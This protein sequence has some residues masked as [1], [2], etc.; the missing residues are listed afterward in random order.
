MATQSTDRKQK[1]HTRPHTPVT[2][3]H[4]LTHTHLHTFGSRSD[5]I[6]ANL[7]TTESEKAKITKSC[8]PTTSSIA[9]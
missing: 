7:K 2:H 9:F 6:A 3:A 1:T 5:I 4:T 8:W